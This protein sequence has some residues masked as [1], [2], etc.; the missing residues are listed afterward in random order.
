MKITVD[1]PQETFEKQKQTAMNAWNEYNDE[2]PEEQNK[3]YRFEIEVNPDEISFDESE[4][5]Q[6]MGG[7][8][9]KYDKTWFMLEWKP[10]NQDLT[11]LINYTVKQLNRFKA[12]LESI[13]SIK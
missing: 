3:G 1:I 13:V 4:G 8:T 5:L 2:C 9:A 6:I 10:D 12:A 11:Q 7:G